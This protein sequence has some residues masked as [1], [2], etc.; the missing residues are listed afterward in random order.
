MTL[1]NTH[2]RERGRRYAAALLVGA[3]TLA[4]TVPAGAQ[5]PVKR[6]AITTRLGAV[7]FEKAASLETS[8]LIGLDAEYGLS[9]FL[10]LGTSINIGR[11]NTH[12]EDFITSITTGTTDEG[13]TTQYYA[14]G[15]S[16]NL[17]EAA[18][19]LTA[20]APM[21]RFTP[22]LSGGAG[23]YTLYMDPQVNR[24]RRQ[25]S[26]L[27]LLVGGGVAI[28]FSER[29]GLTLG[30]RDLIMTGFDADQLDP[31]GGRNRNINFPE[32]LPSPPERKS[33]VN[34]IVYTI[35]FRYVPNFSGISGGR[36]DEDQR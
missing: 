21:G 36:G 23:Y 16:V 33:T 22:Y 11:L 1:R 7:S 15:Q 26:D 12:A 10:A 35:G 28:Q 19:A 9:R 27:S 32:D 4:G 31:S 3:I 6:F 18:L 20:R 13:D 30:V 24:G 8:P 5:A 14:V 17:V 25:L 29:A 2:F 34:S